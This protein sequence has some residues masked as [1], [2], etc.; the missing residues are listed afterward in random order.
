MKT[1][2]ATVIT[3]LLLLCVFTGHGMAFLCGSKI[4]KVNTSQDVVLQNCGDPASVNEWE[5]ERLMRGSGRVEMPRGT[6]PTM[7]VPL[8]TIIH[9]KVQ[10][11]TYDFGPN[12]LRRILRFENGKLIDIK[13]GNYGN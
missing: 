2:I 11:W 1:V 4:I 10:E 5:E 12:H 3:L 7:A 13:T 9:V 6:T 8:K